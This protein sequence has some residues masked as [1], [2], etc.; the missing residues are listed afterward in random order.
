M[1]AGVIQTNRHPAHTVP[2]HVARSAW[3]SSNRTHARAALL[4]SMELF[5]YAIFH[6]LVA[7]VQQLKE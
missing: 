1:A 7:D 5:S 4:G 6:P 2:A 3:T